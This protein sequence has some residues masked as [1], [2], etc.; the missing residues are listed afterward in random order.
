M[1]DAQSIL[2][3]QVSALERALPVLGEAS[4]KL[5]EAVKKAGQDKQL[6]SVAAELK[7]V[8]EK[9]TGE[10]DASKAAVV[11][12]TLEVKKAQEELVGSEKRSSKAAQDLVAAERVVTELTGMSKQL[13]SQLAAA[14]QAAV[15]V[16][17]SVANLQEELDNL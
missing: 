10:L 5:G 7:V 15:E 9:K 1:G 6:A 2:I 3:R 16:G 13:E 17:K 14:R 4:S 11:Q 8:V 12:K